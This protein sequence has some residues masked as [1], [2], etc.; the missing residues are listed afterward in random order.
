M[1]YLIKMTP[2]EPFAFGTDQGF[3][4]PDE[5]GTGKESYFVKSVTDINLS[6]AAIIAGLFQAPSAYDPYRY[7]EATTERRDT[8]LNLMVRHGYITREEAEIAKRKSRYHPA[9]FLCPVYDRPEVSF[10]YPWAVQV[11]VFP[12]ASRTE[13][14]KIGLVQCSG[15]VEFRHEKVVDTRICLYPYLKGVEACEPAFERCSLQSL[16]VQPEG[17]EAASVL[18]HGVQERV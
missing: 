3:K 17:P 18:Q 15:K 2:L 11:E 13:E 8:V 14:G 16:F 7:P 4:Y 12:P 9:L 5:K 6:E 1:K 10:F